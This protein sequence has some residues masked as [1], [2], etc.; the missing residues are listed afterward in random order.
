MTMTYQFLALGCLSASGTYMTWS[1]FMY[2]RLPNPVTGILALGGLAACLAYFGPN[3]MFD[4]LLHMVIALGVGFVVVATSLTGSGDA[5]YYASV[6]AWFP[7]AES[8]RL[9]GWVSLAGFLLTLVWLIFTRLDTE[10]ENAGD[11]FDNVP[12]GVAIASG[13]VACMIG[14]L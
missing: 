11:L 14:L 5:K 10:P 6:A 13:S 1:D 4:H 12:F 8:L 3:Q 9:V 2:R 7:L